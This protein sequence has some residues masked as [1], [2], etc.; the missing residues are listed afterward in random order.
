M[1]ERERYIKLYDIYKNLLTLK[2]Q[3]YFESYYFDDLSFSE[4]SENLS[5]SKSIVGKTIN[6]IN[7]KLNEYEEKLGFLKL[8]D[9]IHNIKDKNIKDSLENLIK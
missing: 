3:E 7:I 9:A 6:T 4:I 8:Y 5:V 1:L 2:Q